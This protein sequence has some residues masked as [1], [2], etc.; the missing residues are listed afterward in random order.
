VLAHEYGH[1]VQ[2]LTGVSE[3][4]RRLPEQQGP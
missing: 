1:H 4:S 3:R 2:T